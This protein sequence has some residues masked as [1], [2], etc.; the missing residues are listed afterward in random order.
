MNKA[1]EEVETNAEIETTLT[2]LNLLSVKQE[3][4]V[5]IAPIKF[6]KKVFY[7][8]GGNGIAFVDAIEV[9]TSEP[10]NSS[11][12]KPVTQ[13]RIQIIEESDQVFSSKPISEESSGGGKKVIDGAI[14]LTEI[15]ED[16]KEI[17]LGFMMP[18]SNGN[19][20][21]S[22]IYDEIYFITENDEAKLHYHRV[23]PSVVII[24][25]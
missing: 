20:H 7:E 17:G 4:T 3:A 22:L 1:L 18:N 10:S 5:Q 23:D 25:G 16:R 15:S 12:G 8:D 6:N 21:E 9:A 2:S 24:R 19:K 11:A 14:F 13:L